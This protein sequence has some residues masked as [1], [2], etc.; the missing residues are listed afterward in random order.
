FT[1]LA[2]NARNNPVQSVSFVSLASFSESKF[3]ASLQS[4]HV[5]VGLMVDMNCHGVGGILHA[6][7]IGNWN[8]TSG[9]ELWDNRSVYQRRTNL[10]GAQLIGVSDATEDEHLA[11]LLA[12]QLANSGNVYYDAAEGIAL[13]ASGKYAFL[14]DAQRAY[15]VIQSLY[16]DEQRCALQEIPLMAKTSIHLALTKGSPAKELLRITLHRIIANSMV[17]YGRKQCYTDKPRCAENEVKMPEVN[18]DQVSS[19]LVMQL[20]AVI[21]SI[22]ILLLELAV[23]MVAAGRH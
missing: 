15:K 2:R 18:L 23:K 12:N 22:A 4:A 6:L 16:T 11:T 5:R 17:Q 19:V 9:L 7:S 20:G 1:H 3:V 14:C 13:M 21:G 8:S 10:L